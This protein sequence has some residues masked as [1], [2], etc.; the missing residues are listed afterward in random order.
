MPEGLCLYSVERTHAGLVLEELQPVEGSYTGA[1][2]KVRRK[3]QHQ[4]TDIDIIEPF[5]KML[6][7][8][9]NVG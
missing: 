3:E 8:F 6:N 2:K 7:M 1:G 4:G 5:Y 9:D